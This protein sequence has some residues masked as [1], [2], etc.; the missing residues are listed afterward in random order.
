MGCQRCGAPPERWTHRRGSRW[1]R[2]CGAAL[3]SSD[4][5]ERATLSAALLHYREALRNAAPDVPRSI[6]ETEEA[7]ARALF[8]RNERK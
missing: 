5:A 7:Q 8:E 1:C 6:V 4:A 2:T 3:R